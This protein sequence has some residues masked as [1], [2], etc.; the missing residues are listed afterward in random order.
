MD[1]VTVPVYL[2]IVA[3]DETRGYR[4]TYR[5]RDVDVTGRASTVEAAIVA[6]IAALGR[7]AGR[8]RRVDLRMSAEGPDFTM[9][10]PLGEGAEAEG[11]AG[12]VAGV[13]MTRARTH[14]KRQKEGEG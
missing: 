1:A 2:R 10:F 14:R 9:R 7:G 11:G 3:D 12:R 4:Y 13:L 5:P 8:L 6:V